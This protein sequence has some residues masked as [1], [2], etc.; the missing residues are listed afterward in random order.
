MP[1]YTINGV[2]YSSD[3]ELSENEL[4]ELAGSAPPSEEGNWMA[5]AARRGLSRYGSQVYGAFAGALT[6]TGQTGAREKAQEAQDYFVKKTGGAGAMPQ[7]EGQKI[8]ASGIELLADPTAY[9]MPHSKLVNTAKPFVKPGLMAIENLFAGAGAE[10]GGQAGQYAG[11]KIGGETGAQVGRVGGA[12]AG[13]VAGGLTAGAVARTPAAVSYAVPKVKQL[14]SKLTRSESL[15]QVEVQAAKHIENVFSA[16]AAADPRFAEVLESA[17]KA[18]EA[19]GVK[20]PISAILAD[21]KVINS[22]LGHLANK[23][24]AFANAYMSQFEQAKDVLR[25]KSTKLF[26]APSMADDI[27]AANVKDVD[28]SSA[29][30]KLKDKLSAR[31]LARSAEFDDMGK[32]G[33]GKRISETLDDAEKAARKAAAPFYSDAFQI[34]KAKGLQL[35]DDAVGD[36]YEYVAGQKASDRFKTFPTIHGKVVRVFKPKEEEVIGIVDNFGKPLSDVSAKKFK[37]ASIEDLDS[38]K[39]EVNA[40]LRKTNDPADIRLLTELK[41]KVN[42]HISELDDDFSSAYKLADTEYLKRVGLPF[43]EA[44]IKMMDRAKF[45]ESVVPL[46]TKNKS[47]LQQFIDATGDSGKKIAE[48]AFITDLT[49]KAVKDG[50]LNPSRAKSW[51]RANDDALSMLPDVKKRVSDAAGDVQELMNKQSLLNERFIRNTQ[52]RIVQAEGKTA[53][54]IVRTMYGSPNYTEKFLS[55]HGKNPETLKAIRSFLLDDIISSGDP[56]KL[57]ND[58]TKSN[59]FNRVFGDAYTERIRQLAIVSDRLTKNPAD[60]AAN[61]SKVNAGF[62]EGAIGMSPQT[63]T[64]VMVTNPVLSPVTRWIIILNRFMNKQLTDRAEREMKEILLDPEKA[65]LLFKSARIT[66]GAKEI[67]DALKASQTLGKK[68][69]KHAYDIISSDVRAGAA[70]SPVAF[71]R[72][73]PMD[74]AEADKELEE[75]FQ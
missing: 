21:N 35:S 31:I 65:V 15:K 70:R 62:V 49:N 22:Y 28:V 27:L 58:R 25:G 37:P 24:E 41:G 72:P 44:A 30:A 67:K 66:S 45:D 59:A 53:Q 75:L 11:E 38:L 43:N 1:R 23:D 42:Q 14:F 9:I 63:V 8:A 47:T 12:L 26:G 60:V 3:R 16:A 73:E 36:I 17:I 46:L 4:E 29:V 64:S 40:Q 2:T 32:A 61:L 39:R 13:G 48:D 33:L 34:A 57:L 52:A 10:A 68:V 5:D 54:D 51:L 50:V 71:D 6:G 20:M 69:G 56:L 7:T 55:R 74:A 18:Q 19:T